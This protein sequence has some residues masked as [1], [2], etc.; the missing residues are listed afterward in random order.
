MSDP[1]RRP[2]HSAASTPET[3]D[4][5]NQAARH[6]GRLPNADHNRPGDD[7]ALQEGTPTPSRSEH[8]DPTEAALP[9]DPFPGDEASA[10]LRRRIEEGE[11]RPGGTDEF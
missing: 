8:P 10:G 9:G 2:E 11:A 1:K 4:L 5:D 7:H 6:D 3:A